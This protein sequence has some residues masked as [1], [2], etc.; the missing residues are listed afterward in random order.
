MYCCF[1]DESEELWVNGTDVCDY[2]IKKQRKGRAINLNDIGGLDI[3]F[4]IDGSDSVR[5]DGFQKSLKF[6]TEVVK[7]IGSSKRCADLYYRGTSTSRH[8]IK[9]TKTFLPFVVFVS[10]ITL[11]MLF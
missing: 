3:V 11:F 10:S 4:V 9:G 1:A 2:E 5:K 7:A 6:A 8:P